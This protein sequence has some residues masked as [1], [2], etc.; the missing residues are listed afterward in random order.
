MQTRSPGLRWWTLSPTSTTVPAASWPDPQQ[1]MSCRDIARLSKRLIADY[2]AIADRQ[3][4]RLPKQ[5]LEVK[6]VGEF[7]TTWTGAA[8][9][10]T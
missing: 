10:A 7:L 2:M 4:S 6:A 8:R 1:R 5:A 3:F 9:L